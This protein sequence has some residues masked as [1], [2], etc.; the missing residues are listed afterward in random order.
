MRNELVGASNSEVNICNQACEEEDATY[1]N[2]LERGIEL[3]EFKE[4]G[5][6][7]TSLT[8]DASIVGIIGSFESREAIDVKAA[9]Q[10]YII[11]MIKKGKYRKCLCDACNV[12]KIPMLIRSDVDFSYLTG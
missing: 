7:P 3:I 10:G 1:I 11:E 2:V 8:K 12:R 5:H 9:M 6:E 4:G